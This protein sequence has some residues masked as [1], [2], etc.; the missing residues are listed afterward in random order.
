MNCLLIFDFLEEGKNILMNKKGE[1]F[2]ADFGISVFYSPDSE[3]P[4]AEEE[5]R[6][7][8]TPHFLSPECIMHLA[9]T[10]K[11]DIWSLGITMF[12]L[13]L[14]YPPHSELPPLEVMQKIQDSDSPTLPKQQDFSTGFQDFLSQCL[15]KDFKERP[16]AEELLSH[17]WFSDLI[18]KDG[19][20]IM[21]D[22]ISRCQEQEESV[23][24]I[25]ASV[26]KKYE[27]TSGAVLVTT[28]EEHEQEKTPKADFNG[29]ESSLKQ[30][31][32]AALS[33][34]KL[35]PPPEMDAFE[36]KQSSK[37]IARVLK[38][39]H[40]AQNVKADSP[41]FHSPPPDAAQG[42]TVKRKVMPWDD[43]LSSES[44][45]RQQ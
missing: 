10:P 13:V 21:Q 32:M 24:K 1:I 18:E 4:L 41:G 37:S 43:S 5:S 25:Q 30:K 38:K 16:S 31:F 20:R 17:P 2:L 22:V 15:I 11:A 28:E 36:K 12:E 42:K 35:L 9:L 44:V 6:I 39:A 27:S 14:G 3:T 23:K 29:R 7:V 26:T 34:A 8:G 40:S 19:E 33:D 45:S